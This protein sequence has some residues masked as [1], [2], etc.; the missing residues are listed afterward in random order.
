MQTGPPKRPG[1]VN[2]P[3]GKGNCD[4]DAGQKKSTFGYPV[5]ALY[6]LP[7]PITADTLRRDFD[8]DMGQ[9]RQYVKWTL[10]KAFPLL[11]LTC[12]L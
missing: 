7:N 12:L 5:N 10:A 8:M 9:G 4:F 1:E 11:S 3:T 2:D 6:Q